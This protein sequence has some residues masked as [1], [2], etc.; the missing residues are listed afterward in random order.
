[1]G[2]QDAS[3]ASS[4]DW[5]LAKVL[6]PELG[7]GTKKAPNA[8]TMKVLSTIDISLKLCIHSSLKDYSFYVFSAAQIMPAFFY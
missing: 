5:T 7:F 6:A 1:L 8:S 2:I 3:C 4:R